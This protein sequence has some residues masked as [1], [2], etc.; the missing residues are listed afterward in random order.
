MK[1]FREKQA[2][3]LTAVYIGMLVVVLAG[4]L[5]VLQEENGNMAEL[6]GLLKEQELDRAGIQLPLAWWG[7]LYPKFCF[8]DG[9]GE[10]AEEKGGENTWNLGNSLKISF[11]LAKAFE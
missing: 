4:H 7:T 8:A 11:W 2:R 3:L 9:V 1:W 10:N 6:Q 5:G